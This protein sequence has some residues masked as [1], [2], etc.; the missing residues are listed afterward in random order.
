MHRRTKLVFSL[1]AATGLGIAGVILGPSPE[2]RAFS[3]LGHALG[4]DQRDVRVFDNF[5]DPEANDNTT[6]HPNWPGYTGA[7]LA[8]W[9]AAVEWGS[10]LHGDGSG[11]PSQPGDVGSGDSNFDP[12]WQGN[13]P[14]FGSATSNVV[15]T[16]NLGGG[17]VIATTDLGRDGWRIL[18][19][20]AFVWDDGPGAPVGSAMDIQAIV[21]HEYGHAL[22]LGHSDVGGATMF[23]TITGNGLPTRSIEAD[24]V[25]GMQFLYG[26]Q[27]ALKPFI[28]AASGG[29]PVVIDGFAFSPTDNEVWFTQA[30]SN[31]T[32]EPIKVTG[33]SSNGTQIQIAFPLGAGPGDVLVLNSWGRLSNA[34][35]FAT[36]G[37]ALPETY[38]T[39]G[40]SE[41][42]C[43][44][45]MG[46]SGTPSA[47]APSGF[48]AIAAGAEGQ[49]HGLFYFGTNGRQASPWGNGTSFQCVVP[50]VV[51]T[52][53]QTSS[54]T[55]GQCNGTFAYDLNTHWSVTKPQTNPGAGAKVQIQTWYRDPG[56]TSSQTTSLSDALEATVCP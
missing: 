1:R 27:S 25:A 22:G 8:V 13:A 56:N 53:L 18:L 41:H 15:A 24:D 6:P 4:L 54:G 45:E 16:T 39:A 9:K 31:P 51:R 32:G 44:A 40:T 48:L 55:P 2:I 23:P 19:N 3:T 43:T 42:G 30:G 12:T 34:F 10:I 17:G 5:A 26:T 28:G 47:S 52:P 37:C 36:E 14:S 46:W 49:H 33:V 38:C 29:N 35:P 7:E 50:P 11:D 20:E 21:T